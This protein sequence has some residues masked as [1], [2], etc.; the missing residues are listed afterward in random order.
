MFV[1]IKEISYYDYLFKCRELTTPLTDYYVGNAISRGE[2]ILLA[3]YEDDISGFCIL[4][5]WEEDSISLDY[6][7]IKEEKRGKSLGT[8]LVA[9][10]IRYAKDHDY[11]VISA[12]VVNHKNSMTSKDY[13]FIRM[14]QILVRYGFVGGVSGY[15]SDFLPIST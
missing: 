14:D 12:R 3:Y 6:L 15:S 10:V 1:M 2:P 5:R 7:L 11:Q 8:E 13:N 9:E 4:H